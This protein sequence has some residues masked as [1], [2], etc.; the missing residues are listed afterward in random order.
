MQLQKIVRSLNFRILEEERFYCVAK[1][2][3]LFS[4]AVTAQ[5]ICV[6][7][8]ACAVCWL[9][10]AVA[11]M[12]TFQAIGQFYVNE[13]ESKFVLKVRIFFLIPLI[14]TCMKSYINLCTVR[15]MLPQT[16]TL[17]LLSRGCSV[18]SG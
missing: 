17:S 1:P 15:E 3:T 10:D 2:K 13:S 11:F 4:C 6:F 5:L 9:S 16:D 7:V 18:L 12:L 8:F 14:A